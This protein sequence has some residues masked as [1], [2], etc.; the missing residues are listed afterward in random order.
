MN[1]WV[2]WFIMGFV[3]FQVMSIEYVMR[4]QDPMVAWGTSMAIGFLA[5]I[6]WRDKS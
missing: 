5:W 6:F 2:L 3:G 4:G 1:K